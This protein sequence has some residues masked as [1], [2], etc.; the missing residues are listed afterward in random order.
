MSKYNDL[1]LGTKSF[2]PKKQKDGT[3]APRGRRIHTRFN[4]VVSN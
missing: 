2:K 3:K 4:F 1:S